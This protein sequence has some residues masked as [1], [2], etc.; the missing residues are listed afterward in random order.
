M[1]GISNTE[2]A[3]SVERLVSLSEYHSALASCKVRELLGGAS[4]PDDFEREMSISYH[5]ILRPQEFQGIQAG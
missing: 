2:I 1:R 4:L 3:K 5:R